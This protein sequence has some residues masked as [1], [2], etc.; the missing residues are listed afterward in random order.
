LRTRRHAS[1]PVDDPDRRLFCYLARDPWGDAPLP[2][3]LVERL[4]SEV[5]V[6]G[7]DDG[8]ELLIDSDLREGLRIVQ[9]R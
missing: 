1:L 2:R 5:E 9:G 4:G 8:S 3:L 7:P 6:T